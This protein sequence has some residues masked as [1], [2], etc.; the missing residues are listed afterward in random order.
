MFNMNEWKKPRFFALPQLQVHNTAA[1]QQ[2]TTSSEGSE[3]NRQVSEQ[4]ITKYPAVVKKG[5]GSHLSALWD[6]VNEIIKGTAPAG[7]KKEAQDAGCPQESWEPEENPWQ[8]ADQAGSDFLS[9][10]HVADLT[11]DWLQEEEPA[12]WEKRDEQDETKNWAP[13]EEP[14]EVQDWEQNNVDINEQVWE[15]T[16]KQNE[17]SLP[18]QD[19]F[20]AGFHLYD[21]ALGGDPGALP[22]ALALWE[23]IYREHP[24]NNLARAYYGACLILEASTGDSQDEFL[25]RSVHGLQLV[26]SALQEE[27]GNLR[28]RYLRAYLYYYKVPEDVALSIEQAIEDFVFL[29]Q[30]Y[31]QD[32]QAFDT[33]L[34]HQVMFDLGFAYQQAGK[35]DQAKKIWAKLYGQWPNPRYREAL[36]KLL[37]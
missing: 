2:H 25:R 28:L 4:Q 17:K 21:L 34:Y 37:I 18:D 36:K 27:P 32:N 11:G 7:E 24:Q 9:D 19:Q 31:E 14:D 20:L 30:T 1:C 29:Q 10:D 22:S 5:P 33:E 8:P 15:A 6:A 16:G 12:D 35:L 3:G 13:S 26:N 23:A